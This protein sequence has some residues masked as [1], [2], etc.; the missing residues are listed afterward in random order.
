VKSGSVLV[1]RPDDLRSAEKKMVSQTR[2]KLINFFHKFCSECGKVWFGIGSSP[3][4]VQWERALTVKP[5][6]GK[7]PVTHLEDLGTGNWCDL[8]NM[9]W[10]FR[11]SMCIG[12]TS[13]FVHD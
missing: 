7:S 1:N 6:L 3:Q 9:E 10:G 2:Q 13:N 5:S 11:H 8:A 12:L 4:H